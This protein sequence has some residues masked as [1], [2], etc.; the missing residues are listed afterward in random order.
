MHIPVLLKEVINYF[1]P[2]PNENYID[3]TLGEGGHSLELLKRT[4]PYGRLLGIDLDKRNIDFSAQRFLKNQII[5][6]RFILVQRNF[7]DIKTIAQEYEFKEVSGILFDLG[8]NTYFLEASG[9][10]FSYRK[11]EPLDMRFDPGSLSLT[12]RDIIN[13]Y[14]ELALQ[15]IFQEY[16]EEK[17]SKRIAS[18]IIKIRT[19]EPIET[20]QD[21]VDI[22]KN[23]I[24][25]PEFQKIHSISRIF[26]A[27]R[28]YI[29][30]ELENLK[31]AL[32]SSLDLL[33]SNA[34]LI[35]ISFH[36]LEDRIVK[37]IFK[38]AAKTKKFQLLT[39][40][41][42]TPT[43][44]EIKSNFSSHSAKMRVIKKLSS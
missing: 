1:D 20:T 10:G 29:N 42:I 9:R 32:L 26:Q 31:V 17:Y 8:L 33:S 30:D 37:N 19:I 6:Q 41:P 38:E 11:N 21:L 28:I 12:A 16:G 39:K 34:E 27:L 25:G 18:N 15:K 2:K 22:I 3:A 4:A 40:K 43:P 44:E 5:S 14:S 7:K 13:K 24:P 36:S 35:V 23:S